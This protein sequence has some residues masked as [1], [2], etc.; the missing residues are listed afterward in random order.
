MVKKNII[1]NYKMYNSRVGAEDVYDPSTM[2][3]GKKTRAKKQG[4]AL[5]NDIGNLAVPFA[6]LLAKQGLEHMNKK[7]STTPKTTTA[8]KKTK[9]ASA[10]TPASKSRRKTVVGGGSCGSQCAA[11]AP[12]T[13]GSKS[14]K[15]VQ[16]RFKKIANEIDSFL[17]KN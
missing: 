1:I 4:G 14:I 2:V 3:G 11:S 17:R 5:M 16:E 13:G 15:D 6:I 12:P 7:K 10:A 8:S 9:S